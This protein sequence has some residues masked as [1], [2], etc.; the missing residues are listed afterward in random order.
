MALCQAEAITGRDTAFL[1][2]FAT[3]MTDNVLM[4]CTP[5]DI[6]NA[7]RFV[8]S[9]LRRN[10]DVAMVANRKRGCSRKGRRVYL[11][12][13]FLRTVCR[14]RVFHHSDYRSQYKDAPD[15]TI[16][17]VVVVMM[18]SFINISRG[19]KYSLNTRVFGTR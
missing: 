15:S 8:E 6:A 9:D 18:N 7:F 17:R 11:P 12:Y 5:R 4:N 13:S 14:C 19:S 2:S 10:S 1:A 16:Y 3:G